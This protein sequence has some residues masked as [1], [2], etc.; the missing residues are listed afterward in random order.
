MTI[1]KIKTKLLLP[2][3]ALLL[4]GATGNVEAFWAMRRIPV[5]ARLNP[6]FPGQET[7][8]QVTIQRQKREGTYY[9][10]KIHYDGPWWGEGSGPAWAKFGRQSWVRCSWN[11]GCTEWWYGYIPPNQANDL[12]IIPLT[13]N[14]N[15]SGTYRGAVTIFGK[16]DNQVINISLAARTIR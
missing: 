11:T 6:Y 15:W 8:L 4:L 3:F 2:L 16:V 7:K 5:L 10:L 12:I 9:N 14:P 13:T 1:I